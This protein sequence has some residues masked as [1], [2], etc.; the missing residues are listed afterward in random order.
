[1]I[2]AVAAVQLFKVEEPKESLHAGGRSLARASAARG[3]LRFFQRFDLEE[4]DGGD[5]RYPNGPD[6]RWPYGGC[7]KKI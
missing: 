2:E 1:M 5:C 4:L 6:I 3:R 7:R